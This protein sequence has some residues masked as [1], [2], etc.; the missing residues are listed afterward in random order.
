MGAEVTEGTLARKWELEGY[1]LGYHLPGGRIVCEEA[2]VPGGV[3]AGEMGADRLVRIWGRS[4]WASLPAT[5]LS[6]PADHVGQRYCS[7][8]QA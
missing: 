4:Y 6:S 8:K 3:G 5:S 1:Q 7:Q 2:T